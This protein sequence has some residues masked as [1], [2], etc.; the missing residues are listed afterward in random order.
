MKANCLNRSVNAA[1]EPRDITVAARENRLDPGI[2]RILDTLIMIQLLQGH[3][4][5][6]GVIGRVHW[7]GEPSSTTTMSRKFD[8]RQHEGLC[9]PLPIPEHGDQHGDIGTHSLVGQ[10]R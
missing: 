8:P 4:M 3:F 10:L 2:K 5:R 7:L 9:Q 1:I 6:P